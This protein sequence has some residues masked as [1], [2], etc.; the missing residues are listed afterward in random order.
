MGDSI[1][2]SCRKLVTISKIKVKYDLII[3]ITTTDSPYKTFLQNEKQKLNALA[4][5]IHTRRY[6]QV[7]IHII[8]YS[9]EWSA[10]VCEKAYLKRKVMSWALNPDTM[11]IF[12]RL[13]A[14][15]FLKDT[16]MKNVS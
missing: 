15:E 9:Q 16:V 5:T 3:I 6:I 13:V 2:L 4:H 14:S 8:Y 10:Q 11:G 7:D 12:C 1:H